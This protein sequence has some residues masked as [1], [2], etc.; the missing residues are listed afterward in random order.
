[1]TD[2]IVGIILVA[3]LIGTGLLLT[4]HSK[5]TREAMFAEMD[6][7]EKE[8]EER[9]KK[10]KEAAKAQQPAPKKRRGRPRGNNGKKEKTGPK[11]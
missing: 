1:M 6:R 3:C 2:L 4:S 11:K 5:K 8:E 7:L 9:L 10:E